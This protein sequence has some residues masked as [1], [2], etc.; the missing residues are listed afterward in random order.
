M[1]IYQR[2]TLYVIPTAICLNAFQ[3]IPKGLHLDLRT[4][5]DVI[6]NRTVILKCTGSASNESWY[7]KKGDD[8][9]I[10]D[11]Y[12]YSEYFHDRIHTNHTME[13]MYIEFR[14]FSLKYLDIYKCVREKGAFSNSLDLNDI[15]RIE[16]QQAEVI[17]NNVTAAIGVRFV[18]L[19]CTIKY[20]GITCDDNIFW[21]NGMTGKEIDTTGELYEVSCED[22]VNDSFVTTSLNINKV[23]DEV[24]RTNY[25]MVFVNRYQTTQRHIVHITFNQDL[26]EKS[27]NRLQTNEVLLISIGSSV[28]IVAI[29][30]TVLLIR[31]KERIRDHCLCSHGKKNCETDPE[32][33]ALEKGI[34]NDNNT[35]EKQNILME[36]G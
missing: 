2:L 7:L 13:T 30:L 22:S 35:Q 29:A 17:C 34:I 3:N 32:K 12:V 11:G 15:F 8:L 10:D 33:I 26:P 36:N 5:T 23:T 18:N 4:V 20:T 27:S 14:T 25:F 31:R 19:Q 21:E 9:L 1:H 6:I 16:S 24:I 28:G